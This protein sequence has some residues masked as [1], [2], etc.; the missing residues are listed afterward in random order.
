MILYYKPT[1]PFCIRVINAA[2]HMGTTL[3]LRDISTDT[4]AYAELLA[5][6]GK[7]QVPYLVDEATDTAMYESADIIA[8]LQ[9]NNEQQNA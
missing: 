3:D 9:E 8:Y 6:G 4:D 1:C 2:Q 5:K 7:A